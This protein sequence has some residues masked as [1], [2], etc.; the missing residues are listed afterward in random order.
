MRAG[1]FKFIVFFFT[2][3]LLFFNK[4]LSPDFECCCRERRLRERK[5]SDLYHLIELQLKVEE[6]N[7]ITNIQSSLLTSHHEIKE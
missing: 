3:N 5:R 6:E 7:S 4:N 1:A 2:G